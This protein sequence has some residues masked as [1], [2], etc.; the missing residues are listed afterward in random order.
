M[1]IDTVGEDEKAGAA[2]YNKA[3]LAVYDVYVLQLSNRFVWRCSRH[4]LLEHYDANLSGN[5]LD[6]GPGTGWYLRNAT[7]PTDRPNVTLM[8]LN[9]TPMQVTTGRLAERGIQARSHV[10]SILQPI[11]PGLGPFESVAANF[12]FHCVPGT[13]QEKGRAFGHIANALSD[14][15][16]FFGST[17]LSRGVKQN[18]A[19]RTLTALYNGRVKAFHNLEDDVS[20]LTSALEAAFA[21]VTVD[22]IGNVAVFAARKP[23]APATS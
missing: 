9:P 6:I 2:V 20:G 5:H 19:A 16:V 22:V 12:V 21:S 11:A 7:F 23:R 18:L 3:M 1:V 14:R 15:G 13:W 10:G 4:R 8:D 17:I